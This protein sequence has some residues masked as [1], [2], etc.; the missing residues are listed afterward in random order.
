MTLAKVKAVNA[1]LFEGEPGNISTDEHS[2]YT[3]YKPQAII[4][5]MN[6]EFWGAWGFEELSSEIVPTGDNKG[7]LLAVAQVKVWLKDV[8]G[9]PVGWGQNRVTRGDIGD[10]RKGAQTDAI[11]KALS[12]FSIGNRA[13][14]GLLKEDSQG[15]HTVSKPQP[16]AVAPKRALHNGNG[17]P[18]VLTRVM[19]VF[20]RG[21]AAGRW[22]KDTFYQ[23][24]S[25]LL[26]KPITRQNAHTLSQQE[27]KEIDRATP[28][29]VS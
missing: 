14:Q 24:I 13:Y 15:S 28:A 10:A 3:G 9:M 22:T 18:V 5:A 20:D 17:S 26:G 2:G 12:Y 23:E 8:S 21:I 1:L 6:T 7:G 11:K 25:A 29:G 16:I 19:D 27:L 4:D